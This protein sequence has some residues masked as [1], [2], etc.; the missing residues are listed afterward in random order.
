MPALRRVL[1]ALEREIAVLGIGY[2]GAVIGF[3]TFGPAIA[4]GLGLWSDTTTASI[5]FSGTLAFSGIVGT[6]VGGILLDLWAQHD[7]ARRLTTLGRGVDCQRLT[8][9]LDLSIVLCA[10]GAIIIANAAYARSQV[11]LSMKST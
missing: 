3:S 4:V 6:P 5:A 8:R 7:A 11:V 10:L 2:S 9:S 1:I